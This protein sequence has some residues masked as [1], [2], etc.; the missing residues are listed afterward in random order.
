MSS[1]EQVPDGNARVTLAPAS[2][3]KLSQTVAE[4]LI[5][6]FRHLPPGTKVPSERI[7]TKELSVGRS[8]VREALN[9][10]AVLG[11]L[12]IRHGQGAFVSDPAAA[13]P[14]AM[15]SRPDSPLTVAL[16]RG[17]TREFIEA[18]LLVE[19]GVARLAAERRTE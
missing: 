19:V 18:R 17:V 4:Q 12:E 2:R 7:L 13:A 3:Q 5:E 6:A 14:D 10:L 8:T 16:E 1:T 11:V 15:S 9:G